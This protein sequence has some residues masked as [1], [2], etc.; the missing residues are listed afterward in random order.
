MKKFS[1]INTFRGYT[2]V[3]LAAN[4]SFVLFIIVTMIY[5]AYYLRTGNIVPAV[6]AVA[7]SIEVI[8]FVLMIFSVIGYAVKLRFL[9]PLKVAMI[10]Y[11]LVEFAIMIC[12]FN[13]IDV[14]EFYTPASKVL[15]IS[16]CIFS[17]AVSMFYMLLSPDKTCMQAACALTAI[18]M[19]LATFSIV[20][21]VRVYA[22]VLVNSFAYIILYS[23]ILA[24]DKRE[25]IEVNCHGDVARVYEDSGF[26][27]DEEKK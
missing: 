21:N 14:S 22:S 3:G 13:V 9:M 4:I 7:Y 17:A 24:F 12:D 16:H 25:M 26:F 8:G 19:M 27:D 20:Y 15:I 5:Y 23:L 1:N 10:V 6:E 18:I 11:F 2:K